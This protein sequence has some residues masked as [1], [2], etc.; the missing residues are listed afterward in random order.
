MQFDHSVYVYEYMLM[1]AKKKC[2][3][4]ENRSAHRFTNAV[5][6][7]SYTKTC[8]YITA[9][10]RRLHVNYEVQNPST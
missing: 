1:Q 7:V 8:G 5:H 6:I 2:S 4:Q 3:F 9:P 10:L